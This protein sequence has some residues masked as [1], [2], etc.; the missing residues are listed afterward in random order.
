MKPVRKSRSPVSSKCRP[1][2]RVRGTGIGKHFPRTQTDRVRHRL[3][4]KGVPIKVFHEQ[5]S[6]DRVHS[7]P[8]GYD[9]WSAGAQ[10]RFGNAVESPGTAATPS[11]AASGKNSQLQARYFKPSHSIGIQHERSRGGWVSTNQHQACFVGRRKRVPCKMKN[12]GGGQSISD[13]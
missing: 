11:R 8:A 12:L 3:A 4:G 5:T 6:F 1:V 13:G 10:K 7:P 2:V 9:V